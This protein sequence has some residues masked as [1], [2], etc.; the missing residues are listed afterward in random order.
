MVTIAGIVVVWVG[1]VF[2]SLLPPSPE[3]YLVGAVSAAQ[4]AVSATGTVLLVGQADL[5]GRLLPPY[6]NTALEDAQQAAATAAQDLLVAPVP[7]A[8]SQAVRQ[9]L[10]PLLVAASDAVTAVVT[11][12]SAG[13]QD[14]VAA[15]LVAL[16]PVRDELDQFVQDNQ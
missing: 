1:V 16:T 2:W 14:E 9:K 6:S 4:D 10:V 5:D 8:Q 15:A 11:A 13:H 12:S 7:D 3:A